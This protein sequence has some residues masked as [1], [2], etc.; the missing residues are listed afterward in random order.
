MYHTVIGRA[1]PPCPIS[2]PHPEVE[3]F[4][5]ATGLWLGVDP[6]LIRGGRSFG[7][8][9][10]QSISGSTSTGMSAG[11]G[12][13]DDGLLLLLL[14][15]LLDRRFFC[16]DILTSQSA[17][18]ST[19]PWRNS[20]SRQR[21][22]VRG[23]HQCVDG[24][25]GGHAHRWISSTWFEVGES[26]SDGLG[27]TI[28]RSWPPELEP[29][30]RRRSAMP[31]AGCAGGSTSIL[32]RVEARNVRAFLCFSRRSPSCDTCLSSYFRS[33]ESSP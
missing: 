29:S 7:G 10:T 20:A 28:A 5:S 22:R 33:S 15:S 19:G 30:S 18:A 32:F 12:R 13:G 3:G 24:F 21:L 27:G 9:S 1:Q 8:A 23:N 16:E 14:L 25:V 11:P 26:R 4:L 17:A 31:G 6:P 2:S